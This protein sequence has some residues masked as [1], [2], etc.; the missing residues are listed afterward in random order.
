MINKSPLKKAYQLIKR[1]RSQRKRDMYKLALGVLVDRTTAIYLS[2]LGVYLFAAIFILGD[3][4]KEYY[5]YFILIEEIAEARL[6]LIITILPIRY[7]TQ[8]FGK[9]GVTFSSSEYQLSL[10]PHNR[11]EIWLLCAREKWLKQLVI[12]VIIGSL[13]SL[14]TPI[15]YTII[16][17]YVLLFGFT[18]ILM[19]IPQW[20]LYQLHFVK[21][22][23]WIF[24]MFI[25]NAANFYFN[26]PLI[27]LGL[28]VFL[29][30]LNVRLDRK[31]FTGVNWDK[32]T[33]IS[34][35]QIWTMWL[36]SKASEVDIKQQKKY[37]VFQNLSIRKRPFT[38][39]EKTILNRMWSLYFGKN[40]Q[41]VIQSIG[42]MVVL[43]IVF[44]YVND[45]LFY[46]G[47]ALV[48]HIYTSI[49]A[50]FFKDQFQT[51]MIETLPW[52]LSSYKQAFSKWAI[53]GGIILFIPIGFYFITNPT[54]LLPF[55][56][57]LFCSTFV[58]IY[59]L[60]IDQAIATLGKKLVTA[61]L[62]EVMG[63]IFLLGIMMSKR[64]PIIAFALIAVI[65]LSFIFKKKLQ[66]R[67]I[68]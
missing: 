18:H 44:R 7:M 39:D 53:Y 5:D 30:Y 47:I 28:V 46:F 54:Y 51:Q 19:T 68:N 2:I 27:A 59:H 23:G 12:Y 34:D 64:Y 16:L 32:V 33:E 17:K 67:H 66:R 21:K 10:L 45:F 11:K 52:K 65:W 43:L 14:M 37:S 57:L 56:L 26:T 29:I 25:I 6:W 15:S 42:S 50:S 13:I 3:F 41:L 63:Y 58:Y 4:T 60:K 9:P 49:L 61:E 1:N 55:E 24:L 40:Y 22:I 62:W 31:I 8:S 38:Y 48:I 36:I 35:F 20:K